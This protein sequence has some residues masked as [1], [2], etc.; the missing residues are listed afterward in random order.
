LRLSNPSPAIAAYARALEIKPNYP[1]AYFGLAEAQMAAR[2]YDLARRNLDSALVLRP[3]YAEALLLQGKLN[4][5]QGDDTAAIQSYSAAL[6]A[7][8]RLAEPA[9]R[10]ALLYIRHDRLED[11][12][13]DLESAI[14]LQPNFPEAH[15]WLGRAY[16]AQ[17]QPKSARPEFERAIEQRGGTYAEASFY[18]TIAR[19]QLATTQ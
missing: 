2:Q 17:G 19:E 18:L 3:N 10:R 6:R 9:Y 14:G 7:N 12:T 15:Y 13:S 1:E 8:D 5:Q 11:A 4:E 16:L